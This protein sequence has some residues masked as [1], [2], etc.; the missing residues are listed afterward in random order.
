MGFNSAFKGLIVSEVLHNNV[1]SYKRGDRKIH[2]ISYA[3]VK[4]FRDILQYPYQIWS[5]N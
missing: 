1:Q 3:L 5:E 2:G 4:D